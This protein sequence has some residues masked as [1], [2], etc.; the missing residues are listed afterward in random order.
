MQ[1]FIL[2]VILLCST[3]AAH[4]AVTQEDEQDQQYTLCLAQRKVNPPNMT[5]EENA[6]CLKEAGIED[7]GEPARKISLDAWRSCLIKNAA[8]LD[9][10]VSPVREV[11]RAVVQL[12]A[13]EW[14]A[15]VLSFAMPPRAKR[16]M[17]NG[18]ETYGVDDGVRTVLM[19]RRA[20][21]DRQAKP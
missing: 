21:K 3:T 14:R 17:A 19:V 7:P 20:A 18:L 15:V 11:T 5:H 8:E 4:A 12:C 1:G 10:S 6:I 2:F 9:D 16:K 13:D